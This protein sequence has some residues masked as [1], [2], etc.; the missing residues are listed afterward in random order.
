MPQCKSCGKTMDEV[1]AAASLFDL[2]L[3]PAD[4][5]RLS[6]RNAKRRASQ[7]GPLCPRCSRD[8]KDLSVKPKK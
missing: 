6:R 8:R 3:L 5:Y 7:V 4:G 1:A 2:S